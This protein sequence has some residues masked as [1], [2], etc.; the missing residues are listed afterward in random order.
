MEEGA[1]AV[2]LGVTLTRLERDVSQMGIAQ[3]AA[4]I[5][6]YSG[7]TG[8]RS[9]KDWVDDLERTRLTFA[10]DEA[11]TIGVA[12]AT[13]EKKAGKFLWQFMQNHQNA[14]LEQIIAALKERFAT[15]TERVQAQQA[16]RSIVQK[17]DE[18]VRNFGARVAALAKEA[19]SA[20]DLDTAV[21]QDAIAECF[22]KGLNSRDAQ[23]TVIKL[24]QQQN[25]RVTLDEAINAAAEDYIAEAGLRIRGIGTVEPMEVDAVQ[26]KPPKVDTQLVDTVS[27][28]AATTA[29]TMVSA[30]TAAIEKL[31]IP[32][33]YAPA[34]RY[35]APNACTYCGRPG[36]Y[37]R[38]CRQLRARGFQAAPPRPQVIICY[39][40]G[41]RG[42]MQRECRQPRQQRPSP[43]QQQSPRPT[44]NQQGNAPG[45]RQAPWNGGRH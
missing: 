8:T 30:V 37:R 19:Y 6:K 16:L 14:T 4:H 43:P 24:K 35:N 40:C 17:K 26:V 45:R 9:L 10:G 5:T 12:L 11:K 29:E 21:V 44:Q 23:K 18:L 38:D 22:L 1:A 39:N 42:H 32:R 34:T 15:G 20:D 28:L 7:E 25:D 36:H 27:K 31:Q 13:V 33:Q 41:A 3:H 2:N